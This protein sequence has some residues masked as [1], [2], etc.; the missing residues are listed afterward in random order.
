VF[1]VLF[2]PADIVGIVPRM[3]AVQTEPQAS[4]AASSLVPSAYAGD[5]HPRGVYVLSMTEVWERFSFYGMRALLVLYLIKEKGFTSPEASRVYGW[6]SA[7]IFL[8]CAFGGVAGDWQLGRERAVLLGSGLMLVGHM[9]MTVDHPVAFYGALGFLVIGCGSF[10]PNVS[11]MV[12]RLYTRDDPRR[13]RGF[14]VFYFGIAIGAVIA[15]LVCGFLAERYGYRWGF[16]ASAIGMLFAMII[17][18]SNWKWVGGSSIPEDP[19]PM[20]ARE[21]SGT[22]AAP[23]TTAVI[24]SALTLLYFAGAEQAG[25][26]LTLFAEYNTARSFSLFGWREWTVPSAWFVSL[27]PLV[28]LA[29]TPLMSRLWAWMDRRGYALSTI[30]KMVVGLFLLALS[31][32][33][34]TAA[35]WLAERGGAR[36]SPLWLL[37][38]YILVSIA[39]LCF[40]PNGV[41]LITKLPAKRAGTLMGIWSLCGFVGNFLAGWFGEQWVKV[42]HAAFF[43]A[44]TLGSFAAALFLFAITKR[45]EKMIQS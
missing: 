6:Y 23:V 26:T 41:S 4:E 44:F 27:N 43:G 10:K 13:D 16:G 34:V 32:V 19:R 29:A 39:E 42:S 35:A 2:L 3:T 14:L 38:F 9:L 22:G 1:K 11:I 30:R 45:L 31:F 17:L 24:I 8:A 7:L 25:N 12:G 20:S 5:Q 37:W 33:S 28:V 18:I 36:V 21:G 15:P 40:L